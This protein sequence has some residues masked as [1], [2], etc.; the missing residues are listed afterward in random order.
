MGIPK[1]GF[2]SQE[3]SATNGGDTLLA[4]WYERLR[5]IVLRSPEPASRAYRYMSR[6]I[7]REFVRRGGDGACLAFSSTDSDKV[8]TDALLLLAYCLRS[9]LDSRVLL[10]DARLKDQAEGITGRLGLVDSPG[11]AEILRDGCGGLEDLIQAT[12]VAGV[13]VLPAGDP[14]GTNS[15]PMDRKKLRELLDA[16]K[17]RYDHVLVQV[18]SPMRDTRALMAA[19]EAEAVF[20][21]AEENRTFVTTLDECRKVLIDNGVSD[22]RVVVTGARP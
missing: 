3:T 21:L 2:L 6:L 18:G 20:L 9:E 17:A 19:A 5:D 11:F 7:E 4:R 12:S 15:T 8:S 16:A 22:V 1:L 14:R 10:M 13:E